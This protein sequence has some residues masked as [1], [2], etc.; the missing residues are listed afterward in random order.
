MDPI[1]GRAV[2]KLPSDPSAVPAARRFASQQLIDFA[3]AAEA[4]DKTRLLV[5]EL[6]TNAIV[7]ARSP[8]RLTVEPI[9][10]RVRV[11]V[12]DDDPTPIAAPKAPDPDATSGRGLWL[13]SALACAWGINH[14]ERG[15]TIWFEVD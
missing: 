9:D 14:N 15:K 13:V 7:H 1:G 11:E 2:T 10:D 8:I 6:T 4:V 12:R 5:T 3:G